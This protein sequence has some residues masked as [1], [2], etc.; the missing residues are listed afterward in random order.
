MHGG[1]SIH[2]GAIIFPVG[3]ELESDKPAGDLIEKEMARPNLQRLTCMSR[4]KTHRQIITSGMPPV[5]A[6]GLVP[7]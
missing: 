2:D 6:D 1:F 3:L 4:I 5:R 7:R